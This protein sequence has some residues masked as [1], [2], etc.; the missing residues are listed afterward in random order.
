VSGTSSET[1]QDHATWKVQGNPGALLFSGMVDDATQI[2]TGTAVSLGT[3]VVPAGGTGYGEMTRN[4]NLFT[5]AVYSDPDFTQLLGSG[6]QSVNETVDAVSGLRFLKV[7]RRDSSASTFIFNGTVDNI[8]FWNGDDP[9][10][11]G[12]Q[13]VEVNLP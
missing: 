10:E 6:K 4:G 8:Q 12:T 5:W 7:G 3:N 9:T 1:A 2:F 13:W 11:H